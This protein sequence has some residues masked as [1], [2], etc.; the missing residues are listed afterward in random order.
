[1]TRSEWVQRYV[2]AMKAGGSQLPEQH[3]IDRAEAGCDAS[4]EA[5]DTDPQ[6]WEAPEIIADEDLEAHRCGGLP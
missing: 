3:L 6:N 1:M 2:S 5:G 4:D